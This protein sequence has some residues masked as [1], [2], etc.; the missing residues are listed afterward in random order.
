MVLV[1]IAHVKK[2]WTVVGWAVVRILNIDGRQTPAASTNILWVS[3]LRLL[4]VKVMIKAFKVEGT[5]NS[6]TYNDLRL[7]NLLRI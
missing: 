6:R 3:V 2:W 1:T 5:I 4:E 7:A